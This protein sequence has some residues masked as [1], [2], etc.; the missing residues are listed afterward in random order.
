MNCPPNLHQTGLN[1]YS[2]SASKKYKIVFGE[3]SLKTCCGITTT[4]GVPS[5]IHYLRSPGERLASVIPVQNPF[6]IAVRLRPSLKDEV[7]RGVKGSA[8]K[9]G[10]HRSIGGIA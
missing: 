9:P 5:L 8:V 2:L 7:A 6:G 10:R 1:P 3:N 4:V